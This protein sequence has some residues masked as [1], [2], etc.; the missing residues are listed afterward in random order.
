MEIT[1]NRSRYPRVA[2]SLASTTVTHPV[3]QPQQRSVPTVGVR[4]S[5]NS[6]H[7]PVDS[8][9]S[10]V[11]SHQGP[12]RQFNFREAVTAAVY[13]DQKDKERRAK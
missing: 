11:V 1:I 12:R 6:A 13:A 5:T 10:S 8:H 7:T 3:Q 9:Q 2:L 4:A